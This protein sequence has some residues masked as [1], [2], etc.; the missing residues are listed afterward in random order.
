MVLDVCGQ[1]AVGGIQSSKVLEFD[2]HGR[3]VASRRAAVSAQLAVDASGLVRLR[4]TPVNA[5]QKL[6]PQRRAVTRLPTVSA[7]L[8][9]EMP[10]KHR[11]HG[12]GDNRPEALSPGA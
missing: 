8:A 1:A 3:A 11:L 6:P 9:V 5:Q 12:L 4:L 10:P 7:Q 2:V